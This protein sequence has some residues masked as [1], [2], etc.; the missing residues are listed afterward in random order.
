MSGREVNSKSSLQAPVYPGGLLSR[1]NW[2]PVYS[3]ESRKFLSR[4]SSHVE[5]FIKTTSSL[6]NFNESIGVRFKSWPLWNRLSLLYENSFENGSNLNGKG[7]KEQNTPGFNMTALNTV[8]DTT[9]GLSPFD[10]IAISYDLVEMGDG[11]YKQRYK[12][13]N[14]PSPGGISNYFSDN[15]QNMTESLSELFD[16]GNGY[17]ND[18]NNSDVKVREVIRYVVSK[19]KS[20]NSDYKVGEAGPKSKDALFSNFFPNTSSKKFDPVMNLNL[21]KVGR[22]EIPGGFPESS[23]NINI[24]SMNQNSKTGLRDLIKVSEGVPDDKETSS[25]SILQKNNQISSSETNTF[26]EKLHDFSK[27]PLSLDGIDINILNSQKVIKEE[28]K[29]SSEKIKMDIKNDLTQN[30]SAEGPKIDINELANKV[31]KKIEQKER[32][33]RE[34]KGY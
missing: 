19:N 8:S 24:G 28:V 2:K 25:L 29:K 18:E 6:M 21:G 4:I 10:K 32:F 1:I 16:Y 26:I 7:L 23:N 20:V 9:L 31:S 17:G 3:A 12:R 14:I 30:L 33:E 11:Q 22:K 27:P 15:E 34:R 13:S 5:P